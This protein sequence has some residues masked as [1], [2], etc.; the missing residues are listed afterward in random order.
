MSFQWELEHGAVGF[1]ISPA[2]KQVFGLGGSCHT[3]VTTGRQLLVAGEAFWG[4]YLE[5]G[6]ASS[7]RSAAGGAGVGVGGCGGGFVTT[8]ESI[9][10][11][12]RASL[13]V[14]YRLRSMAAATS[15]AVIDVCF[16]IIWRFARRWHVVR[17][18]KEPRARVAPRGIAPY[19]TCLDKALPCLLAFAGLDPNVGA[20]S[21]RDS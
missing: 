4:G 17:L 11:L 6:P 7:G 10:P 13:G 9:N 5:Y 8:I 15:N 19:K 21:T 18:A 1:Y 12:S 16:A 3:Q 2:S 20:G 14:R